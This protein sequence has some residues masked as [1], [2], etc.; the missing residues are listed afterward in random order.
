MAKGF[1]QFAQ[2]QEALKKAK[3]VQQD[4]TRLQDELA[5]TTVVGT[6]P[7]GLVKVTMSGNQEPIS[8]SIDPEALKEDLGML[9][10]LV[11]TAFKDA[12]TQSTDLMRNKMSD[13]T[14]GISVPGLF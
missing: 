8:I 9:E 6:A 11:L 4:A 2:M 13:L 7:G 12:Y 1:G 3:Q 10:D 14:G 5:D